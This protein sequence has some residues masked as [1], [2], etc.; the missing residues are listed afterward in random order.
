MV[1]FNLQQ[2]GIYSTLLNKVFGVLIQNLTNDHVLHPKDCVA[3][4]K[5]K[6]L[7]EEEIQILSYKT[8]E[9]SQK[10]NRVINEL[11]LLLKQEGNYTNRQMVILNNLLH[12]LEDQSEPKDHIILY[13]D[14]ESL[15]LHLNDSTITF[16][17]HFTGQ[18]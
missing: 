2:E 4:T 12:Q 9:Q 14:S 6:T 5:V 8:K 15:E 17:Y 13:T 16:I 11:I 7:D 1:T 3:D 10:L 18:W